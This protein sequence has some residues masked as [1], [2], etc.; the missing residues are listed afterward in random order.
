MECHR[1]INSRNAQRVLVDAVSHTVFFAEIRV[2][3]EI[4]DIFRGDHPAFRSIR[5]NT[6]F[7][8]S[9]VKS[10]ISVPLQDIT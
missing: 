7:T 8:K 3:M 1:N 2:F 4:F 6:R 10:E 9:M 5:Y